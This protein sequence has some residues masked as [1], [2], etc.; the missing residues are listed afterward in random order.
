MSPEIMKCHVKC[1]LEL[2]P[3]LGVMVP[4]IKKS[5]KVYFLRLELVNKQLSV[6]LSR[7]FPLQPASF[8]IKV[9]VTWN[10]MSRETENVT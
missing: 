3:E 7:V 6:S 2:V 8:W 4:H 10:Q 9:N 1:H 5:F